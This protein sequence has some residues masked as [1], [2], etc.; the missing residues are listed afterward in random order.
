[1]KFLEEDCNENGVIGEEFKINDD[2][3]VYDHLFPAWRSVAAK[4][5]YVAYAWI[6]NR[7]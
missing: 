5:S 4:N 6:D 2:N 7:N 1:M 3:I